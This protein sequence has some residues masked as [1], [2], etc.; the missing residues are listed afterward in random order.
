MIAR[1]FN[2]GNSREL[3]VEYMKIS[4]MLMAMLLLSMAG[5]A[6]LPALAQDESQGGAGASIKAPANES[7]LAFFVQSAA[8]HARDAGKYEAI[9]D[10]M[11]LNS[12]WVRGDVYIFAHDFNGTS[13]CLPF[14]P[15]EVGTDRSSIQNDKGVYINR[16]MRAIALNG[17]G[18]YE[19]DW[20]NP[21]TNKSEPKVSYVMKVDDTWYLG[22]G[23]YRAQLSGESENDSGISSIILSNLTGSVAGNKESNMAYFLLLLQADLQGKLND[24]DEAVADSSYQLSTAGIKGEKAR[25][26]LQN[27]T[28]SG[29][30]FLEA[31]T[32]SIEGKIEIAEPAAYRNFEGADISKSES[33]IR[34]ML[35]KSPDFSE[36]L[37]LVEGYNASIISYPVFSASGQLIGAVGAIMRPDEAIGSIAVPLLNGTNYSV[38]VIQKDGLNLY[39]T[40]SSQ[41]GKNLFEDPI[42]KPYPQLLAL[43]RDVVAERSG[44][45]SYVFLNKEHNEN[46][47]KEICWTTVGLHDNEWRLVA[48]RSY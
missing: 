31:T 4:N 33:T 37:R 23:I 18:Y 42:Y 48:I 40:D 28:N 29:S 19:Y 36:V 26:I 8:A 14:M 24:L 45:G 35:T 17:S 6:A 13:L 27:L 32:G 25:E 16:N 11:D 43:G 10:F 44:M 38:T 1:T 9:K 20:N 39:D 22:A 5:T 2:L 7:E 3:W 12:S 34:L 15:K 30:S 21:L 47:T 41:I 46:V